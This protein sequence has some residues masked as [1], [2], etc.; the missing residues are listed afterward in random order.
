MDNLRL[1]ATIL[2][3]HDRLT[4]DDRTRLHLYLGDDE[5]LPRRIRDDPSLSGTLRL[6]D[7]LFDRDTINNQDFSFLINAL[8]GIQCFDAANLLRRH[9]NRNRNVDLNNSL[10]S[11]SSIMPLICNQPLRR[12]EDEKGKPSVGLLSN[13]DEP[14]YHSNDY[15]RTKHS[16]VSELTTQVSSIEHSITQENGRKP[17]NNAY[18]LCAMIIGSEKYQQILKSSYELFQ[19][20]LYTFDSSKTVMNLIE[21]IFDSTK[22]I[23]I[24][25][26]ICV[27]YQNRQLDESEY[28]ITQSF[29]T[30][31]IVYILLIPTNRNNLSKSLKFSIS[32]DIYI[33]ITEKDHNKCQIVRMKDINKDTTI[34]FLKQRALEILEIKKITSHRIRMYYYG[35]ELFD[36]LRP[37]S[38]E[39]SFFI[40]SEKLPIIF[41][42]ILYEIRSKSTCYTNNY[43]DHS[44]I[45]DINN[46]TDL[47]ETDYEIFFRNFA[48]IYYIRLY[49]YAVI[50]NQSTR[51]DLSEFYSFCDKNQSN[52][53]NEHQSTLGLLTFFMYINK[54]LVEYQLDEKNLLPI[55]YENDHYNLED[56]QTLI[57]DTLTEYIRQQTFHYPEY[58][59]FKD[60]SS[61]SQI[62]KQI[63]NLSKVHFL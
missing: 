22:N 23:S 62:N 29:Q 54:D 57:I 59:H 2:N 45:E 27:V 42:L 16:Y 5:D 63:E 39:F 17:C 6:M 26:S 36:D 18:Q 47:F 1:R 40:N 28:L 60:S 31:L 32:S 50:V 19:L 38:F 9:L 48:F 43:D 56:F 3:I 49:L 13:L 44:E 53:L 21:N 25:L 11:L 61:P 12:L 15:S 51:N 20:F 8:D 14:E 46:S 55:I 41:D 37:L 35:Y 34:Q 7:C 10:Q 24:D 4:A 58:S 33:R 52:Q 30:N